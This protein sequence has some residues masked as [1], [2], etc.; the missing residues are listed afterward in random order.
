MTKTPQLVTFEE[1]AKLL[2]VKPSTL[3]KWKYQKRLDTVKLGR[4]VRLKLEDV[5]RLASTGLSQMKNAV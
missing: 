5:E 3:R 1:A 2:A 4:S